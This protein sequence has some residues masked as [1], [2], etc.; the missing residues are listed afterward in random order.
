MVENQGGN[1][2]NGNF[3]GTNSK[4]SSELLEH[5]GRNYR[6]VQQKSDDGD[7]CS[8]GCR[9]AGIKTLKRNGIKRAAESSR[10][11]SVN[12][13]KTAMDETNRIME[14]V[15]KEQ[16][17]AGKVERLYISLKFMDKGTEAYEEVVGKIKS[18]NNVAS[19]DE[20]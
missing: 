5:V 15:S 16:R 3:S 9:P 19:S 17:L 14:L 11:K 20:E 6:D 1:T 4:R 2:D 10:E 13:I 18:L 8:S 7:N 12:L